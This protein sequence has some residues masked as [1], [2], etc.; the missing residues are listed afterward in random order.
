M[1]VSLRLQLFVSLCIVLGTAPVEQAHGKKAFT[2]NILSTGVSSELYD[3]SSRNNHNGDGND[4]DP[5]ASTSQNGSQTPVDPGSIAIDGSGDLFLDVTAAAGVSVLHDGGSV[6]DMG[7]GTGA[8]WFDYDNDG[9]QDLYMTMRTGANRLFQNNNGVFTD[10]AVAAGAADASHDGSGVAVADFDN[11]GDKDIYLANSDEDVLLRNN[12]DGTFTDITAGS[13]LEVSGNRRGTSASWGDFDNDGF[14]DLYVAHHEPM[15][16]SGVPDDATQA[17]DYFFYN[18]GDG[19]FTDISDSH[20]G[21]DRQGHSFIGAFTDYDSDGDLDILKISDCPFEDTDT[22]RLWRNDG[23]SNGISN[24]TFTQVAESVQADWCQN[25]MGIAVGDYDRDGDMDYFSSDNGSDGTVPPGEKGRAGTV[26]FRNDGNTFAEV[27]LAAGV[28]SAAWSWGANFFDFDLD[29]YQDLYLAAG[30]MNTFDPVESVLWQNDGDGTFTNVSAM[31][32]GLNDAERTRTS[33]FA[34]YDGDGDPDMFLVNYAGN[35]KLFEN[36]ADDTNNWVIVDLQGTESNRDGIGARLALTTSNGATQ[37]YETRSGSSLGGGDDIGAY[38]GLG[39]GTSISSLVI[40]WPSGTVQTINSL[41]VNQR[42]LIVE[43][44]GSSGGGATLT[45]SPTSIDFGQQEEGTSSTPV[46]VSLTNEGPE[47]LEVSSLSMTGTDA[48]DFSHDFVGPFTLESGF[49]SQFTVT[50]SPSA[51]SSAPPG[52][53][54]VLYR[55]NAGGALVSDWEEDSDANPSSY[56]NESATLAQ[57]TTSSIT[58]DSTVPAGTPAEIFQGSRLDGAKVDPNM[59]W[60]F[61]VTAGDELTVRL[62]F[63]EIVRCQAGGH[64]F[65]V[66]IE[67]TM[68]LDDFDPFAEVG[69]EVGTM[70][71]FVITP[72]DD[73]LDINFLLAGNNRPSLISAIEIETTSG[74]GGGA[75]IRTAQIS[76]NHTGT[77]PAQTIDLTGEATSDGG[78]G[79][80]EPPTASFTADVDD[81]DVTFTDGSSDSDGSVVS[82]SWDFG[83]GNTSADQNP[84]YTYAAYGTYTVSLVVTDDQGAESSTSQDVTVTEPGDPG[85]GAFIEEGGM[86][87]MEA[88]N[89]TASI[90]RSGRSWSSNSDNAGFSGASAMQVGPDDGLFIGSDVPTTSPELSF[91][92]DITT[93]GDY[94]A[95]V[96]VWAP[97]RNAN[98]VHVGV[99]GATHPGSKGIQTQTL[100]SWVWL[101]QARGNGALTHTISTAGIHTFHVWM[102]EDGAVVDKAI[103]TTDPNFVPSGEGPVESPR[104]SGEV[105]SE[106]AKNGP[107]LQIHSDNVQLPKEFALNGNYPNPFNPTT[108]IS[109]ALPE[110]SNVTLEVFDLM[111]RRVATLI[112]GEVAAGMHEKI[113]DA[114]SDAGAMVASGVYLYRLR[115][116]A[117]VQVRRMVLMK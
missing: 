79:E 55:I 65:D 58:L 24:W 93:T 115:A 34:D 112:S 12:G 38:F 67:G 75:D 22:Y 98:S 74:T 64:V 110:A 16:G 18:N 86:V 20:L 47:S 117:F 82:W 53:A 61:P 49:T 90:D 72:D 60:D 94:Y 91:D 36:C 9:D 70:R 52:E 99:D 43:D 42:H 105:V 11:D 40:T 107:E 54:E 37:Y 109:F 28:H 59:E 45:V 89:F 51:S 77:N 81:L 73:N 13:G 102:R 95:W 97:D 33:V 27:T 50:F 46:T 3:R 88:E 103:V 83:D 44:G 17:Q 19:T 116:G 23:G 1:H 85:D 6:T 57:T 66:E 113:W 41:G 4:K 100:G 104:T 63:A 29:G 39:E 48:A 62:F 30:A 68:V 8:A 7:M 108:T 31:S 15:A 35:A 80:N 84:T 69:C 14:L 111:G 71:E 114:H 92:M 76:V 32:G 101:Q 78:G 56:V 2:H 5:D 26:L 96:R 106:R 21:V 10:V 87:V 25:G